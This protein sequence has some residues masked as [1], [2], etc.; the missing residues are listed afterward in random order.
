MA[1][2]MS[3]VKRRNGT[4]PKVDIKECFSLIS[5]LG[6]LTDGVKYGLTMYL[7]KRVKTRGVTHL[8]YNNFY[9]M[10]QRLLAHCC[11]KPFEKISYVDVQNFEHEILFH[12]K[13]AT[14]KSFLKELYA[15]QEDIDR[16]TQ[17][18]KTQPV[19]LN[20]TVKINQALIEEYFGD[21]VVI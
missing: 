7:R 12:I 9:Q 13:F 19:K 20:K 11:E 10:I 1:F 21:V 8:N 14:Q 15:T 5:D 2:S 16:W 6:I 4:S 3:Q 17:Y 18:D